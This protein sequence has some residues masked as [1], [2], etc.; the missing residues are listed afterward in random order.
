MLKK[1]ALKKVEEEVV[2]K[3]FK[4]EIFQKKRN[5]LGVKRNLKKQKSRDRN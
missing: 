5:E 3:Y 1:P 2:I 4:L